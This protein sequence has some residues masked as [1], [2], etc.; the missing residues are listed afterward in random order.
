[1]LKKILCVIVTALLIV[2]TPLYAGS[3]AILFERGR[4]FA[5]SQK[6]DFAYMQFRDLV[7][8]YP[9]S[10]FYEKALFATGE[11]FFLYS[12]FA[13]AAK[14]FSEFVDLYPKSKLKIFALGYL[15]R[16]AAENKDEKLVEKLKTDIITRQQVALIFRNAKEYKYRSPLD[17][18]YHGLIQIDKIIISCDGQTLAEISY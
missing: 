18:L 15:Y 11:Y 2:P 3:D 7:F 14:T 12:N 16:I 4:N 5:K 8:H 9:R 10:K 6:L 17:R 1:M 13:E